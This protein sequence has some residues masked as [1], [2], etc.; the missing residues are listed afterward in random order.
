MGTDYDTWLL[1]IVEGNRDEPCEE[2][3]EEEECVCDN[4]PDGADLAE[5]QCRD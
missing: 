2:C 3:E 4:G 5:W 1:N